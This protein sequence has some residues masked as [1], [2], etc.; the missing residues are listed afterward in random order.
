[1]SYEPILSGSELTEGITEL[2]EEVQTYEPGKASKPAK[3]VEFPE[4]LYIGLF[5]RTGCG[6]T[7]LINSLKFA[8]HGKLQRAKWL[9][10]AGQEKAGGHTM[11]RKLADIT[12]KIFV[13]DNRGLDEPNTEDAIAELAAQ[14]D[15]K[16]GF[17]DIVEWQGA[18]DGNDSNDL[19]DED[20]DLS[21]PDLNKGYPIGCAVFVFSAR[22]DIDTNT[23][24]LAEVIDFLHSHQGRY[25]VAIITHVDVAEKNHVEDLKIVLRVS[26]VSDIFEVANLTTE[27]KL[28]EEPYQHS[29]LSLLDRCMTDGDETFI[30]KHHQRQEQQRK[31]GNEGKRVEKKR[32]QEEERRKQEDEIR[33]QEDEI[34]TQ[35]EERRKQEEERRKQE[36]E[37]RK[38]EDEIR[39]QEDEIRT[40]EEERR[41]QEEERRKQE[42]E[43]RMQEDEIRTQEDEIRMQEDEIRTQEEER[44]KQEEE[45]RKQEEERRKQEEERRKQEENKRKQDEWRIAAECRQMLERGS[46]ERENQIRRELEEQKR[47]VKRGYERA[48]QLE[49]DRRE[50][51]RDQRYD[52]AI[53]RAEVEKHAEIRRIMEANKNNESGCEIM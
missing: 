6:K 11:F 16:R 42:D 14:L 8:T 19:E 5:G 39:T 49:R 28:L 35:E 4:K 12:K 27:K 29:L 44:R 30:F 40:Q 33:M 20:L 37:R 3:R 18:S 50:R 32:E 43:I 25:P 45:R 47:M 52:E 26:G 2:R 21:K 1:M 22:H 41:K 24:G 15:G 7:S 46:T 17:T 9:Q 13:I 31:K 51:E 34:R 53:K 10:V 23:T 38:Q 48:E 36:E